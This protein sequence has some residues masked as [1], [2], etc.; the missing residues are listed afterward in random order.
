MV[1]Y[2]KQYLNLVREDYKVIRWKLFNAV[3]AKGWTNVLAIIKLLFCLPMANG[4]LER[5]FSQLKLIKNDRRTCLKEDTLDQ[6]VQINVEGPPLSD[7]D[8][9]GAFELWMNEKVWRVNQQLPQHHSTPTPVTINFDDDT[10]AG[11]ETF[12]FDDWEE[13]IES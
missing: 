13:W 11:L 6:L 12:S 5:V 9:S 10:D 3:D 1:G 7:W 2:G 4:R 8:A